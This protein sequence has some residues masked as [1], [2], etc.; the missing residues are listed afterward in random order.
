MN[1]LRFQI[2]GTIRRVLVV[3]CPLVAPFA[4]P[5]ETVLVS[6]ENSRIERWTAQEQAPWRFEG[7]WMD[8]RAAGVAN[9]GIAVSGDTVYVADRAAGGR[10]LAYA[11]DGRAKGVVARTMP[12]PDQL[13]V[14]PDGRHLYVSAL[15]EDVFRFDVATGVGGR[16]VDVRVGT[17]GL[18]FGGDGL[19]YV[20]NRQ[21]HEVDAFNVSGEKPVKVV[22]IPFGSCTGALS[23]F[24]PERVAAFG[25]Q[26][27]VADLSTSRMATLG[28]R[29]RIDNAIG[30]CRVGDAVFV[31]DFTHGRIWRFD[32]TETEPTVVAEGVKGVCALAAIGARPLPGPAKPLVY[33]TPT[34]P[35]GTD[36]ERLSFNNPEEVIFLKAGFQSVD[37]RIMDYDGDGQDD[38][39]VRCGWGVWPWKG[40][41]VYLNP[42]PKGARDGNPVFPPAKRLRF[43]DYPEVPFPP[44]FGRDGGSL[45]RIHYQDGF[46]PQ[47]NPNTPAYWQGREPKEGDRH[48]ADLDGD[49]IDDLLIR[50]GDEDLSAMQNRYDP[51]GNWTTP[52]LRS[53]VYVCRGLGANRYADAKMLYLENE[54][55]LEVYGGWST[56]VGDWDGD[57]DIDLVLIDFMDTATYFEN[58]GTKTKAV[59]TSGRFLRAPDGSRLAWDLCMPRASVHDWDRDG[60]PDIILVE[61][62]SRVSW[63][64]NTGSPRNGMP[65]FEQPR[66]FRQRADEL[67]F[68]SLSCPCAFD[69][70]GDGDE[71]LIVG[72]AHGQIA[73]IEN[74]S[75]AGVERPKWA[76]PRYLTEPDG[77]KIW[78]KAMHDGSIQGPMEWKWGYMTVTVAD[79]DGDGRPDIMGNNIRGEVCWWRNIGTRRQP[80]L[81]FAQRVEVEWNGPQPELGW[82]WLRPALQK[83]PKDLLTQW[84]TTPVMVDWNRDGLMDLVMLDQDGYLAFFERARAADGRLVVKAPRRALLDAKGAPLR[85]CCRWC[86]DIGCGRRKFSVCDWD[87]DGRLDILANGSRNVTVFRQVSDDGATWRFAA[88]GDVARRQ[89]S[90]HDPQP[91]ACD[92]NGDGVP[93]LLLGAMD[94]FIYYYRNPRSGDSRGE[95]ECAK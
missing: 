77:R 28:G 39:V 78:Q 17:R 31:A 56:L 32:S 37:H 62:D 88:E 72:N 7:I 10:V 65:V 73:F 46:R 43:E 36:F 33:Q 93:D 30:A 82:G 81:D 18:A 35:P 13:C 1:R 4:L 91:A 69:W 34:L 95:R 79:W 8:C 27:E 63:C 41:Y 11:L 94:G 42:T 3:A 47:G 9:T 21:N 23:F 12:R 50:A 25:P 20:C 45:G 59:F 40:T 87:G 80:R 90:T 49:G 2:H 38:I 26:S 48:L 60:F 44:C 15:E 61:E 67:H 53:F 71:D 51:R 14:S 70:D 66:Y 54:L 85:P 58:V 5:G 24:G 29:N 19:L 52:Q 16:F 6:R 86:C 76:A 57:G 83:N 64:R 55:P 22:N 75:G 92:F 89:L 74:L 68:G 84:R